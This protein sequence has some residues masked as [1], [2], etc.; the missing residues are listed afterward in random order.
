MK[1]YIGLL[2]LE[3]LAIGGVSIAILYYIIKNL[4][5]EE[6]D[7]C[8]GTGYNG[9]DQWGTDQVCWQCKGSGVV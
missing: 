2:I 5:H 3:I 6:C 7:I 4:I 1:L 9:I 8:N